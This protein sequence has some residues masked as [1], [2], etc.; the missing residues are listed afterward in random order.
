[1]PKGLK[2]TL[3]KPGENAERSGLQAGDILIRYSGESVST[4][5]ELIA[6]ISRRSGISDVQVDILRAG[7]EIPVQVGPGS[8]GVVLTQCNEAEV[9]AAIQAG[10]TAEAIK[11]VIVTTAPSVEGRKVLRTLDVVS[12]EY[13]LGM[14]IL[15]DLLTA[16]SDTFGGRSGTLQNAMREARVDALN[17]LRAAAHELG[18]NAV[19]GTRIEYSEFSGQG[20]S[21]LLVAAY[22]T[23]VEI[24]SHGST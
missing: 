7:R 10:R 1:M 21:M 13:A 22:G 15:K 3:I 24:S 16:L 6:A 19:I 11:S 14:N 23:A 18:A 20:K 4:S 2:L 8:L 17:D 9:S 5:D 12:A